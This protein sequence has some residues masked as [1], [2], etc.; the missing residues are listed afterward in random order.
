MIMTTSDVIQTFWTHAAILGAVVTALAG[1][2]GKLTAERIVRRET[3]RIEKE[4]REH[5]DAIVRRR[6]LYSRLATGLRVFSSKATEEAKQD[7]LTAY[8][9]SCV[10]ASESVI[11]KIGE[12][13][14]VLARTN[15]DKSAEAEKQRKDSYMA[16]IIAMRRDAG[17]P[18]SD[19]R[20]RFVSF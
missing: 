13:L 4:S 14:D 18:E 15:G 6:D 3:A 19:F 17:F 2:M 1:W 20:F 11:Q 12:L 5:Q 16:C 9:Q 10:W 7:F 8:D